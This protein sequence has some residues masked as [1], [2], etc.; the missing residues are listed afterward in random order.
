MRKHITAVD[1]FAF[2]LKS[3]LERGLKTF[4]HR[5]ILLVTGSNCS[6][7]ILRELKRLRFEFKESKATKEEKMFNDNGEIVTVKRSYKVYEVI[8]NEL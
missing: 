4:T 2:W 3:R 5:D 8:S 1:R 7:S 6:Y